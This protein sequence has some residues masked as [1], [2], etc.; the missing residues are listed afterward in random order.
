VSRY[1]RTA[2]VMEYHGTLADQHGLWVLDDVLGGRVVMLRDAWGQHLR[3]R[4][5]SISA[6]DVPRITEH[7]AHALDLARQQRGQIDPRTVAWMREASL[8]EDADPS[9]HP[10]GYRLTRLGLAVATAITR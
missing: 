1:V 6:V 3:C 7:R 9:R 4:T 8:I 2:A 10:R 5:A